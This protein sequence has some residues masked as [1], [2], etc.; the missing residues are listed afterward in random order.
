MVPFTSRVERVTLSIA[1]CSLPSENC[2]ARPSSSVTITGRPHRGSRDSGPRGCARRPLFHVAVRKLCDHGRA[3]RASP[4][5]ALVPVVGMSG[6]VRPLDRTNLRSRDMVGDRA[7]AS[8]VPTRPRASVV[9][10]LM[11]VRR[12][13]QCKIGR[14]GGCLDSGPRAG[15]ASPPAQRR[16]PLGIPRRLSVRQ[17]ATRSHGGSSDNPRRC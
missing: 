13:I 17:G 16:G 14:S 3:P 11:E 8:G 9:V 15:V 1:S 7:E 12:R 10:P 2:E 6:R 4:V 5:D